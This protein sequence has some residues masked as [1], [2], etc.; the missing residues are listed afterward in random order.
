MK[1]S[2]LGSN[3][4]TCLNDINNVN[5]NQKIK[6]LIKN[7]IKVNSIDFSYSYIHKILL[8]QKDIKI[9]LK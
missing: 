2:P 5:M 8:I 6:I 1:K 3:V 9:L 4:S 7:Y